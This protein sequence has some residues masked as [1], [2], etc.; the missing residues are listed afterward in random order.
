MTTTASPLKRLE[1]LDKQQANLDEEREKLAT[2]ALEELRNKRA[3]KLK[4]VKEIEQQIDDV[5]ERFGMAPKYKGGNGSKSKGRSGGNKKKRAK[6]GGPYEGMT[7]ADAILTLIGDRKS[8]PI[9]EIKS[10]L[11]E[12]GASP[13]GIAVACSALKRD[14][15]LK[16]PER[17][18]YA[19]TAKAKKTG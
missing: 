11:A 19:L 9:A 5:R 13:E 2:S 10:R 18:H 3:E 16:S 8:V 4:E 17:G 15:Y 1:E 14:G 12:H 7:Q 6:L